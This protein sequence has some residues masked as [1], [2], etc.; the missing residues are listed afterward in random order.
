MGYAITD[1]E[2]ADAFVQDHSVDARYVE[3]WGKWVTW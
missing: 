3:A 2:A 1:I